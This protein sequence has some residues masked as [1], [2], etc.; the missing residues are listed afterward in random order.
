MQRILNSILNLILN[1]FIII[2]NILPSF[3]TFILNILQ[4]KFRHSQHFF[5]K[6]ENDLRPVENGLRMSWECIENGLTTAPGAAARNHFEHKAAQPRSPGDLSKPTSAAFEHNMIVA[7]SRLIQHEATF[8]Q[9]G[10]E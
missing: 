6:V 1:I 9:V 10:S 4:K 7:L 5:K 2:L 8:Y 3:S